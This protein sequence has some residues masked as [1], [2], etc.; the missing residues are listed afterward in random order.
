MFTFRLLSST[1]VFHASHACV[2]CIMLRRSSNRNFC[3]YSS[4]SRVISLILGVFIIDG[5]IENGLLCCKLFSNK[6]FPTEFEFDISS[7]SEF[8]SDILK[9][10]SFFDCL[11]LFV[12]SFVEGKKEKKTF[13]N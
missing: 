12:F 7:R 4:R 9:E 13:A 11:F 10:E 2:A 1:A 6:L 3:A 8:N 5:D